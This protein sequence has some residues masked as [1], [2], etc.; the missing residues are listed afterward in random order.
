MAG[1]KMDIKHTEFRFLPVSKAIKV[2][3][4]ITNFGVSTVIIAFFVGGAS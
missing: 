3:S 4:C 2:V 1:G